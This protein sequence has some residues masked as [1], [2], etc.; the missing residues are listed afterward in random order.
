MLVFADCA[1]LSLSCTGLVLG[2]TAG[3]VVGVLTWV[4]AGELWL[5]RS[6]HLSPKRS[7]KDF[8][9]GGRQKQC[10]LFFQPTTADSKHILIYR[11]KRKK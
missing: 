2:V 11:L 5:V 8:T 4:A 10:F 6:W 9:P 1:T 7:R 3:V